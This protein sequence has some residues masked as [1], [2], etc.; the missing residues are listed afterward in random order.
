MG[1]WKTVGLCVIALG[2]GYA[3]AHSL[4]G[5]LFGN[6]LFSKRGFKKGDRIYSKEYVGRKKITYVAGE[7][8][9][10]T[11]AGYLVLFEGDID[12]SGKDKKEW[13][14]DEDDAIKGGDKHE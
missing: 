10:V 3:V 5:Q 7:I 1:F 12:G 9:E 2:E 13:Y 4:H 14:I 11:K 8:L 6:S